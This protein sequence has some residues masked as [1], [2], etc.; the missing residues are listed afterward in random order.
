VPLAID[1]CAARR[2]LITI[3]QFQMSPRCKPLWID[4]ITGIGVG[5]EQVEDL[6]LLRVCL[7]AAPLWIYKLIF[8]TL[9][10]SFYFINSL[11][12]V[13][14]NK[15]EKSFVVFCMID[16]ILESRSVCINFIYGRA[17][18]LRRGRH[19]STLKLIN[20]PCTRWCTTDSC[21]S[22]CINIK[23]VRTVHFWVRGWLLVSHKK[24]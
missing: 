16:E 14:R 23:R 15:N 17:S 11:P 2:G 6:L 10:F 8:L 22:I 21:W 13:P 12:C 5:A 3:Y 20:S 24:Y 18:L 19:T 9:S 7:I 1:R 4:A